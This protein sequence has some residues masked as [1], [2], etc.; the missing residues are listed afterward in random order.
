MIIGIG[1]IPHILLYMLYCTLK[2]ILYI[3][4]HGHMRII[5]YLVLSFF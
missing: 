5:V 3:S 1:E 4:E 2:F